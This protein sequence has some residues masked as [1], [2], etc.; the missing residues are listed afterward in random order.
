MIILSGGPRRASSRRTG[1]GK[2]WTAM[3][4]PMALNR[5]TVGL[6]ISGTWAS[7]QRR[8]LIGV[9]A[10][11]C[12]KAEAISLSSASDRLCCWKLQP[13]LA[14][15]FRAG[16]KLAGSVTG[17]AGASWWRTRRSPETRI[18]SSPKRSKAFSTRWRAIGKSV[19]WSMV[20]KKTR[21]R[22]VSFLAMQV[23]ERVVHPER[24]AGGQAV[25]HEAVLHVVRAGLDEFAHVDIGGDRP[26]WPNRPSRRGSLPPVGGASAASSAPSGRRP[27]GGPAAI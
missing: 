19:P 8:S 23:E 20:R 2:G 22:V 7:D 11:T 26:G 13:R 21:S 1:S 4:A 25:E 9:S 10:L 18:M 24:V 15:N 14:M 3:P 16:T 5:S 12:S 17:P 6:S 27:R